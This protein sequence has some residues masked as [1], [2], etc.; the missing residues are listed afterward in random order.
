MNEWMNEGIYVRPSY[1]RLWRGCSVSTYH[2][3]GYT[4]QFL[5]CY[6][7][8]WMSGSSTGICTLSALFWL[9]LGNFG[10]STTVLCQLS[11]S[12][13]KWTTFKLF[14]PSGLL[15]TIH[16]TSVYIRG[17]CTKL[18]HGGILGLFFCFVRHR[19]LDL[20]PTDL[21]MASQ[22]TCPR[23]CATNMKFLRPFTLKLQAWLRRVDG[24]AKG[25]AYR[26]GCVAQW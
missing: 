14:A 22:V 2:T 23:T 13:D 16:T 18:Q 5:V 8:Q 1:R 26:V 25:N 20:W 21:D 19:N 12:S 9:F 7:N 17:I 4:V 15:W 6:R 11:Y 10:Y 3:L 24:Q